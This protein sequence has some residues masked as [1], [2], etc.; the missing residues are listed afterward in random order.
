MYLHFFGN[1]DLENI[2]EIDLITAS[3]DINFSYYIK[4]IRKIV[5]DGKFIGNLTI[6]G[7]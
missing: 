4:W 1:S 5:R 7:I 2:V 3:Y 6:I